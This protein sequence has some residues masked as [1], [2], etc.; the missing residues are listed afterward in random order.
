M[1]KQQALPEIEPFLFSNAVKYFW[2]TRKQ[3]GKKGA[4]RGARKEVTAGKH[5]DIFEST[6]KEFLIKNGIEE[7]IIFTKKTLVR[8][9]GFFRP[10]KEWDIL[11]VSKKILLA[12]IELKSIASSFGKN[13]NNRIEEALGSSIDFWTAVNTETF[14]PQ[15]T[16]VICPW[17]GYFFLLSDCEEIRVIR[18]TSKF[19]PHFSIRDE[20]KKSSYLK[21]SILLCRKLIEKKKYDS[22]CLILSNKKQA[23]KKEN[24][25]EPCNDLSS[26][27]FLTKL[28]NHIRISLE[29]IN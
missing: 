1:P 20:F 19:E 29:I 15:E 8:L 18:D 26:K 10:T 14:P 9:P 2:S 17:L 27:Q 6:I 24:Y 21:R 28:L 23:K 5:M 7:S 3:R 25:S 4:D 11:V 22:A 12:A 13:L 16:T